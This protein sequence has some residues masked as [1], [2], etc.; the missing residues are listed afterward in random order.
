MT[1]KDRKQKDD[2]LVGLM[3]YER[4]LEAF[5]YLINFL[6]N[7]KYLHT[8]IKI[9]RLVFHPAVGLNCVLLGKVA[10]TFLEIARL[11]ITGFIF[12]FMKHQHLAL[13]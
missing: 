3:L 5:A 8:M 13:Y 11:L 9:S 6:G 12:F 4:Y 7:W 2:R 10:N 1:E